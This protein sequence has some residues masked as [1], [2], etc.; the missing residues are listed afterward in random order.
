MHIAYPYAKLVPTKLAL[1]PNKQP[2]L[3]RP[4]LQ[5]PDEFIH[6]LKHRLVGKPYDYQRVLNYLL[7]WKLSL[8]SPAL[9]KK[10]AYSETESR[11][12]CSHHLFKVLSDS[13]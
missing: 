12:V 3:L 5:N 1:L 9:A 10:L 4:K 2:L 8:L 11:V 13:E 7:T 6:Q